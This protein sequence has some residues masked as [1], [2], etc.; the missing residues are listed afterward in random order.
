MVLVQVVAAEE[1]ARGLAVIK[2]KNNKITRLIS[3]NDHF[4]GAEPNEKKRKEKNK[5]CPRPN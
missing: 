2:K 3:I 5:V 1:S 4:R